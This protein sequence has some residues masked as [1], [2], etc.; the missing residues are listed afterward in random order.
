MA[1]QTEP[2]EPV[3]TCAPPVRIGN[4]SETLNGIRRAVTKRAYE[5]YQRHAGQP[6]RDREDWLL[7]KKDVLQPL[8][9]CGILNSKDEAVISVCSSALRMADLA[10]VE[11]CVEG[12][13]LIFVGRKQASDASL[14]GETKFRVLD[15]ADEFDPSSVRIR[16]D[17]PLFEITI[18]KLA[19]KSATDRRAA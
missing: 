5:I 8:G 15:L 4:L 13:R 2:L 6:G 7:A 17:G 14:A 12:H 19:R 10:E 18:H 1:T 16:Q 3:E 9:C 11:V